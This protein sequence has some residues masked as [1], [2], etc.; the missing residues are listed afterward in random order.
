[1]ERHLP[2]PILTIHHPPGREV[3]YPDT[4]I[5]L[6]WKHGFR[7]L[8][9]GGKVQGSLIG[10]PMHIY[11][12]YAMFLGCAW[13]LRCAWHGSLAVVATVDGRWTVA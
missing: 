5:T 13:R 12:G 10:I 8:A 2:T 7:V 6:Q 11:A 1:M 3:R 9:K 4:D